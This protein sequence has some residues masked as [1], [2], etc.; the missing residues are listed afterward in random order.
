MKKRPVGLKRFEWLIVCILATASALQSASGRANNDSVE[1]QVKAAYLLHFAGYVYWPRPPAA[2]ASTPL[3]LGVLGPDPMVAILEK[4]VAGKTVNSRPIRVKEFAAVDP[5]DHCDILFVP[6]SGAK[7]APAV[8]SGVLGRPILTVSDQE[9]FTSQGGIIEF[10]LI[11]D[12]VRFAINREAAERAGL[13]LSSEL[14]RV[15]YSII[16]RRK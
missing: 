5:I 3:V 12:T 13:K 11:D 14:L 9:K 4:T 1:L 6:R 16:G 7:Y 2:D 8:L 15:A 10:L